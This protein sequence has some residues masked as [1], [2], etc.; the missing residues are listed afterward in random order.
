VADRV[1]ACIDREA[2]AAATIALPDPDRKNVDRAYWVKTALLNYCE[3]TGQVPDEDGW[4]E[5]IGDFICDLAHFCDDNNIK[6]LERI[7]AGQMHY[8]DETENKGSQFKV[9]GCTHI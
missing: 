7:A 8:N 2:T 4:E 3:E 1:A 5:I 6:L 9:L